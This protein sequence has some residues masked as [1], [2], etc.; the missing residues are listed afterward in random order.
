MLDSH[1]SRDAASGAA[2][3]A[4]IPSNGAALVRACPVCNA[5]PFNRCRDDHE[6]EVH[7]VHAGRGI[8]LSHEEPA[9]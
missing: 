7:G 2:R 6:D 4:Y 5:Q 3:L 1:P 9:T 8:D